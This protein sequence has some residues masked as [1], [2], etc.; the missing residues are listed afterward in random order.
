MGNVSKALE[1]LDK[2]L[3]DSVSE[4]GHGVWDHR[5]WADHMQEER[6]PVTENSVESQVWLSL[7]EEALCALE[8]SRGR[9]NPQELWGADS[10][11]RIELEGFGQW[12]GIRRRDSQK[13]EEEQRRR[14]EWSPRKWMVTSSPPGKASCCST[15]PASPPTGTSQEK[16]QGDPSLGAPS[17]QKAIMSLAR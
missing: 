2:Q 3:G 17:T 1:N 10:L 6:W 13:R 8:T 7:W 16:P 14:S 15:V 12:G 4:D 5:V 11:M 9:S